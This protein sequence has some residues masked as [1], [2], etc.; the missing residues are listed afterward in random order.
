M[1]S[2]QRGKQSVRFVIFSSNEISL[3]QVS[4][5]LLSQD[6]LSRLINKVRENLGFDLWSYFSLLPPPHSAK[7]KEAAQA[8]QSLIQPLLFRSAIENLKFCH[9]SI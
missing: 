4:L 7:K 6:S 3:I 5:I 1:P 2:Q 8:P 9:F